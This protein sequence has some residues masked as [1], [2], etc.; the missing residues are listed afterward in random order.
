VGWLAVDALYAGI[1]ATLLR[2][3]ET[4]TGPAGLGII[5][6][7][8]FLIALV[9]SLPS[10]VVLAPVTHLD[11]GLSAGGNLAA[12]VTISAAGKAVGSVVALRLGHGARQRSDPVVRALWRS[13]FGVVEWTESRGAEVA[14]RYGYIGP[15]MALCV[16]GVPDTL[17]I[18]AFAVL[19]EDYVKF[20]SPRPPAVPAA[21]W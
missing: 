9:L 16:P 13:R 3:I 7:Y 21:S 20:A 10:E 17:P 18:H 14:R 8:S 15:A 6:V 19:E 12:I 11:A 2:A 5:F 1:E 4:A